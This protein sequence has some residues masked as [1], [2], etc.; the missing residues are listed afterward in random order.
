MGKPFVTPPAIKTLPLGSRIAAC[1]A[2]GVVMFPTGVKWALP[3]GLEVVD[4]VLVVE[5]DV[6]DG[7]ELANGMLPQDV[8]IGMSR[9][10]ARKVRERVVIFASRHRRSRGSISHFTSGMAF[11]PIKRKPESFWLM[12]L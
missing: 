10:R 9:R 3:V 1:L 5:P 8:R 7:V 4:G 2:R 12:R 6:V 11:T